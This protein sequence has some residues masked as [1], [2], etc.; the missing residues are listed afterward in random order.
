ME[1]LLLE[2][3]RN[4]SYDPKRK[5]EYVSSVEKLL[6]DPVV[7]RMSPSTYAHSLNTAL[8]VIELG[9]DFV[10]ISAA[11]LHHK[12]EKELESSFGSNFDSQISIVHH[13]KELRFAMSEFEDAWKWR[14]KPILSDQ[15]LD[16]L[17]Q[18]RNHFKAHLEAQEFR[19]FL[20]LL[21]SRLDVIRRGDPERLHPDRSILLQELFWIFSPILHFSGSN[22][23]VTEIESLFFRETCPTEFR[24]IV[25]QYP[26]YEIIKKTI[27][28]LKQ[29]IK[30]RLNEYG[31]PVSLISYRA[32]GVYSIYRSL[33]R[34]EEWPPHDLIGLRVV[35]DTKEDCYRTRDAVVT[36][37]KPTDKLKDYIVCPKGEHKY[38]ALHVGITTR[39]AK[40]KFPCEI[41]IRS[42]EMD[43]HDEMGEA[44][45]FKRVVEYVPGYLSPETAT[46]HHNMW[47]P[48]LRDICEFF[49]NHLIAILADTGGIYTLPKKA[50]PLD[51]AFKAGFA[52][53][54]DGRLS[55]WTIFEWEK[56]KRPA[57]MPVLPGER[58]SINIE[59]SEKVPVAWI[60]LSGVKQNKEFISR[61]LE[62][63]G[64]KQQVIE[65]GKRIIHEELSE[66]RKVW[67]D[68]LARQN[69]N[70][71]LEAAISPDI[72][73]CAD[74][75][76]ARI[77]DDLKKETD[78]I[79][80]DFCRR[81]LENVPDFES[82]RRFHFGEGQ[83]ESLKVR[84]DREPESQPDRIMFGKCCCPVPGDSLIGI[85]IKR[86]IYY[87]F[88]H[89]LDC[90]FVQMFS[91]KREFPKTDT[92]E[93]WMWYGPYEQFYEAALT[94]H[95]IDRPNMIT[96]IGRA[97]GERKTSIES[98]YHPE[99]TPSKIHSYIRWTVIYASFKVRNRQT[100]GGLRKELEV[101]PFVIS[102]KRGFHPELR[103]F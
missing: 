10:T 31:I 69:E 65:E 90:P 38:M 25:G 53:K 12:D 27:E 78:A 1:K 82:A 91:G 55:C 20:I 47:I 16:K 51:L 30:K 50:K 19:S 73:K 99:S 88:V 95:T 23:L 79:E 22:W 9:I 26:K 34:N 40:E 36:R 33:Q 98:L 86:N 49:E 81:F 17:R 84:R 97:F 75:R 28:N 57:M 32:K 61:K 77:I 72:D 35:V 21:L 70:F 96:D 62:S 58:I 42:R 64:D 60:K 103:R 52:G 29:G 56:E 92:Q 93:D 101:I 37:W 68:I 85:E 3:I 67:R 43:I 45:H 7:K 80:S 5:K 18:F 94:I 39:S 44:A 66:D 2:K 54:R 4:C 6:R 15:Q 59:E 46:F 24:K 87:G 48:Y 100:L 102:A 76:I 11:L 63:Q 83:P 8:G 14:E 41:Q 71:F 74:N 89:R 13:I